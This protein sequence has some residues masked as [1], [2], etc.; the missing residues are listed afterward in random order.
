M[1]PSAGPLGAEDR[2]RRRRLAATA[3]L[4]LG[5]LTVAVGRALGTVVVTVDGE[6]DDPGSRLLDRLLIDLIEGQGNL[7]VA[8]DLGKATVATDA[9]A[10]LIAAARRA[11]G[12]GA[13]FIVKEPPLDAHQALQSSGMGELLEIQPRRAFPR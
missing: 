10:V 8:V 12:R 2:E 5:D 3:P 9:H 4:V 7:T 11:R 13:K 1:S 6:L